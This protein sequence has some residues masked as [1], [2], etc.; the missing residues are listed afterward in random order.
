M[1]SSTPLVSFLSHSRNAAL[2]RRDPSF[3]YRCENLCAALQAITHPARFLHRKDYQTDGSREEILVCHRPR[4]TWR[5]RRWL[6]KVG[7]TGARL[8]AEVDDLVFDPNLASHSPAV[9]NRHLPLWRTKMLFAA[10]RRALGHFE[11]ISTS[12]EPL[13]AELH[14]CFPAANIGVFPNAIPREWAGLPLAS[15]ERRTLTYFPGT[16]G[17][18][19]DFAMIHGPLAEFLQRRPDWKLLIAG[20]LDTSLPARPGQLE[21]L[22]RVPFDQYHEV[23]QRGAINLAPLEPSPFNACKSAL[24]IM[25]AG[26]FGIPTV[27]SPIPDAKRFA[28]DGVE[29]PSSADEWFGAMT[30]LAD[31]FPYSDSWREHLR[32]RTVRNASIGR[33]AD[34]WASWVGLTPGAAR[35]ASTQL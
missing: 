33:E 26:F 14:R 20:P 24:K 35:A 18:N 8:V 27:A 13:A 1:S 28:G 29:V 10:N 34:R 23:V 12:T 25:E 3:F 21:H 7:G 2:Y 6:G 15:A 11:F 22:P 9:R 16:R 4:D 5:W 17:H 31:R 30:R 19:A 32:D